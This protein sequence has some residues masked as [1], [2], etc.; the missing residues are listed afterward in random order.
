MSEEQYIEIREKPKYQQWRAAGG[1]VYRPFLFRKQFPKLYPYLAIKH[2]QRINWGKVGMVAV[3]LV[4][5]VFMLWFI[6]RFM[7]ISAPENPVNMTLEARLSASLTMPPTELA[8]LPE[9]GSDF[10]LTI[11]KDE[12]IPTS[13]GVINITP[14]ATFTPSPT[15]T[16]TST[17]TNTP[18][19]TQTATPTVT[20]VCSTCE[21]QPF[22]VRVGW[23]YPPLGGYHCAA[24]APC[25]TQS[26]RSGDDWLPLL[27]KVAACPEQFGLAWVSIAGLGD[28][29][30]RHTLPFLVCNWA[31]Q[32]CD[33]SILSN[34]PIEGAADWR[35][36]HDA[37]VYFK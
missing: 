18:T 14:S 15:S 30:C 25:D 2:P 26:L 16:N 34:G 3:L 37:I 8:M 10:P 36:V 19:P 9:L 5:I 13:L 17:P 22:G 32:Y 4:G 29:Q 12:I 7:G 24:A 27:G 6:F 11:P 28:F 23:F 31:D 33:I 35:Q 21:S 20:P 1:S